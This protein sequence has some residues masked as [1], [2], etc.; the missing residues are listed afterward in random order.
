MQYRHVAPGALPSVRLLLAAVLGEAVVSMLLALEALGHHRER[1]LH[2]A[3]LVT[4]AVVPVFAVCT[5]VAL[6]MRSQAHAC[7]HLARQ[8][9]SALVGT[10]AD[11]VW[12]TT[13]DGVI[14]YAG[15]QTLNVLGYRPEEVVGR[16]LDAVMAG[17]EL[18]R[19]YELLR[20]AAS[21]GQ[22][23]ASERLIFL[24]ADGRRI[25]LS[26][27]GV[28]RHDVHGRPVGFTGTLHEIALD[29]E[30]RDQHQQLR[31]QVTEILESRAIRPVYQPIISTASGAIIGAEALSR[32]TA[33]PP[34]T[35][36]RWF[37]Q[38]AEF[39]LGEDL[40]LLAA[41]IALQEA[42]RLP[43][44][45]Y[46]SINLSPSTIS[47]GRLQP[48]LE[49]SPGPRR[50][51]VIEI[52]EHVSVTDYDA[53]S[54][55]VTALRDLGVRIAV[56]D[57]GAGYASFRHILQLRPDYIKLDRALIDG[58]GH[59]A[60][61]RALAGAFVAFGQEVG[62]TIVAEGVETGDELRAARSLGMH[63]AQGYYTG[64]PAP[65]DRLWGAGHLGCRRAAS[66]PA[67]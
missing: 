65:L 66:L 26:G 48:L 14:T 22:G 8:R 63:A 42:P 47:G 50:Q 27:S 24:A 52:T 35:P 33:S 6:R 36:D 59:D 10:T 60:A 40:E 21:T 61:K 32:F 9:L 55:A 23:W 29:E 25:P 41:E 19:G 11:V 34:K 13:L 51:L 62:A 15:P 56:D 28:L 53:L 45:V 1:A 46:L 12:E 57:A 37:A 30:A 3:A 16:R 64:R 2:L 7:D 39:G 20:R 38:A 49:R 43:A 67:R 4:L 54:L 44:H 5:C 31:D 58:L 17:G 18:R